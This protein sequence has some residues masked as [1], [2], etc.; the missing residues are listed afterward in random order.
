MEKLFSRPAQIILGLVI[1][2]YML[3]AAVFGSDAAKGVATLLWVASL[4]FLV[5]EVDKLP[6]EKLLS[7]TI[8]T[9][10][11][12]FMIIYTLLSTLW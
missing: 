10:S 7:A 8:G 9:S 4:F 11:G 3:F 6:Q 2:V 12:T 5:I 1:A